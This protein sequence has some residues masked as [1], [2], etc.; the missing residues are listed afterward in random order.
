[1]DPGRKGQ[2]R[3]LAQRHHALRP[4]LSNLNLSLVRRRRAHRPR[5]KLPRRRPHRHHHPRRSPRRKRVGS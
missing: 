1:L 4:N 5:H 3:R 2:A